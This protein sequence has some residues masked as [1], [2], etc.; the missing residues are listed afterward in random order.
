MPRVIR[1]ALRLLRNL[2]W[3]TLRWSAA[4]GNQLIDAL[5][6]LNLAK[7]WPSF[8]DALSLWG[9]PTLNFVY[10]D[11]DGNIGWVAAALTPVRDGWHG[12]LPVPGAGGAHR[13]TRF[14]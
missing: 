3:R 11:V 8:R 14:L 10:A 4:D 13:W 6:R 7:D 2:R 1:D 5:L 12:L 9:S